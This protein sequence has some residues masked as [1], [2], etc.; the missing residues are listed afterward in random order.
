MGNYSNGLTGPLGQ[1]VTS[2][3]PNTSGLQ[4]VKDSLYQASFSSGLASYGSPGSSGRGSIRSAELETSNVNLAQEFADMITTQRGFQ[5]S[6]RVVTA[7]DQ[8]LQELMNVAR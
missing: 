2:T 1:L 6:S 3:F 5:A 4:K 8:M 7:A